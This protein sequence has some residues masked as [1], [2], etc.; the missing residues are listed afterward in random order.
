VLCAQEWFDS[1]AAQLGRKEHIPH[2]H[3]NRWSSLQGPHSSAIIMLECT[4]E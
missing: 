3:H 4:R 1:A 2:R